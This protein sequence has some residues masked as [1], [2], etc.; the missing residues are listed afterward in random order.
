MASFS[1]EEQISDMIQH[2]SIIKWV[3][4]SD[5]QQQLQDLPQHGS[6]PEQRSY[7]PQIYSALQLHLLYQQSSKVLRLNYSPHHL[8][9]TRRPPIQPVVADRFSKS[10]ASLTLH[11]GSN[12]R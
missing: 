1:E 2:I 3:T 12:K 5:L 7:F 11:R 9:F 8:T 6:D 10:F 4:T